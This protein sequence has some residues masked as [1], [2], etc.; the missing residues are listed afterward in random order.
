MNFLW[1]T[2]VKAWIALPINRRVD[3]DQEDLD[4]LRLFLE[5]KSGKRFLQKLRESAADVSFASV[6]S[7]ASQAVSA[8]AYARGWQDSLALV[9]RL[10]KVFPEQVES[11]YGVAG[12]EQ[13]QIPPR[14]SSAGGQSS[15][16]GQIGGGQAL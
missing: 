7:P 15:W 9:Y 8:S 4:T 3:W 11:E 12:E 16:F 1:R 10:S 6:Y 5:S 2:I 13:V 14:G